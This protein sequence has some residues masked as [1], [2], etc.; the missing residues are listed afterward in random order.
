MINCTVVILTYKGQRHLEYLLPTLKVAI[1]SYKNSETIDVLIVDNGK[2]ELTRQ[3]VLQNF[4][5]F[6]FEFS[7]AKTPML[8]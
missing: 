5:C 3:Y 4:P 6:R 2:D 7:P 1:E 8:R